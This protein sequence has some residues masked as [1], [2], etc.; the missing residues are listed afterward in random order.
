MAKK[1]FTQNNEENRYYRETIL[2]LVRGAADSNMSFED[3]NIPDEYV[4]R[5][6]EDFDKAS[7]G[8]VDNLEDDVESLVEIPRGIA[9]MASEGKTYTDDMPDEAG[10][11][12][13]ADLIARIMGDGG[14]EKMASD[15]IDLPMRM[16]ADPKGEAKSRPLDAILMAAP[17]VG[18]LKAAGKLK[19]KGRQLELPLDDAAKRHNGNG[20]IDLEETMDRED[21][22]FEKDLEID[23]DSATDMEM[24]DDSK[25]GQL[26]RIPLKKRQITEEDLPEISPLREEDYPE[27][28]PRGPAKK[29]SVDDLLKDFIDEDKPKPFIDDILGDYMKTKGKFEGTKKPKDLSDDSDFE[30]AIKPKKVKVEKTSVE[31]DPAAIEWLKKDKEKRSGKSSQEGMRASAAGPDDFDIDVV[32]DTPD[33]VKSIAEDM[34]DWAD[35]GEDFSPVIQSDSVV[36]ADDILRGFGNADTEALEMAKKADKMIKAGKPAD[37]LL[38]NAR[39]QMQQI[40]KVLDTDAAKASDDLKLA[41]NQMRAAQGKGVAPDEKWSKMA[42]EADAKLAALEEARSRVM[43]PFSQIDADIFDFNKEATM[44]QVDKFAKDEVELPES[45]GEKRLGKVPEKNKTYEVDELSD[46]DE[47]L[48]KILGYV[49]PKKRK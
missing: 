31:A 37:V 14:A 34:V 36:S 6:M 43:E 33:S 5:A 35:D 7:S 25:K 1:S 48:L 20:E 40:M 32:D 11:K 10:G 2:P 27:I 18:K 44:K 22:P 13:I 12:V 8:F 23:D 47:Q 21:S 38:K 42:E 17:I 49:A 19:K 26:G 41:K 9:K 46:E 24:S 45:F 4:D 15:A 39:A 16:M 29:K 28:T 3:L 30:N